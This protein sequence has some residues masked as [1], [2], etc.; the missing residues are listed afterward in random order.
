MFGICFLKQD[1]L[2]IWT[3]YSHSGISGKKLEKGYCLYGGSLLSLYGMERIEQLE[4]ENIDLKF[5][6]KQCKDKELIYLDILN[7]IQGSLDDLFQ[8]E[9]ESDRFRL[10][11]EFDYREA[12]VNLDK[13]LKEYKRIYRVNF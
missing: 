2:F 11:E 8:R 9:K 10:M 4:V 13:S 1:P 7:N 12:I 6:L 5:E 3:P